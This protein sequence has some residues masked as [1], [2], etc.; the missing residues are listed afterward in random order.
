[1]EPHNDLQKSLTKTSVSCKAL[2]DSLDVAFIVLGFYL[3]I[4]NFVLFAWF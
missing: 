2:S 4:S 3:A 1:M